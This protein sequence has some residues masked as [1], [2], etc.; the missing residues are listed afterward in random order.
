M[1]F[2]WTKDEFDLWVRENG[3]YDDENIYCLNKDESMSAAI[4]VFSIN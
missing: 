1:N 2:F 3:F 4:E